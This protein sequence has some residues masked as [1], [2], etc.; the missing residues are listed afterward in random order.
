VEL[1]GIVEAGGEAVC[2]GVAT[3]GEAG[4]AAGIHPAVAFA[5]GVQVEGEEDDVGGAFCQADVVDTAAAFLEGD[6]FVFG[7]DDAGV[8]AQGG[9]TGLD[10]PGQGAVVGVLAQPS[11][12]RA[13][14][15]RADAVAGVEKC[16]HSW[17][18]V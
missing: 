7:D 12:G 15:G 18:C 5:G 3:G 10:A 11:V 1:G 17:F 8:K 6:V 14:P 2:A 13:L 16:N 4:P 9:E